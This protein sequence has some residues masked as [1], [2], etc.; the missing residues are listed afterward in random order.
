LIQVGFEYAQA[1]WVA[2][3]FDTRPDAESDGEWNSHIQGNELDREHWLE[4]GTS[5]TDEA[6]TLIQ[7]DGS[8]IELPAGT[9]LAEPLGEL[10][11]AIMLQARADGLFERLPKLS[12][13]E[14]D[15]EHSEGAYG[16]HDELE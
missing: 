9:E 1:A 16:W 14:L 2:V 10:L 8:V 6:I 15:I 7:L 12:G 13:C 5:N 4:A 11:K 3:I